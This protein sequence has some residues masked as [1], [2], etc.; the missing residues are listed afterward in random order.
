MATKLLYNNFSAG[1][2]SKAL[3]RMVSS[4]I[5]GYSA[6][7]MQNVYPLSTGGF[8]I[9]DGLKQLSDVTSL[10]IKRLIPFCISEKE[11]YIVGISTNALYIITYDNSF[12]LT[13][14]SPYLD[15][16]NYLEDEI[17]SIGFAQDYERLIL[18]HENHAPIVVSRL[19]NDDNT[20]SISVS[21]IV[22][23][24][25]NVQYEE[26][27]IVANK[28][29]YEGLFTENNFPSCVA[30]ISGRL[31]FASS[32]EN[33]YKLWASRPFEYNNFQDVEDYKAYQNSDN[34]N[35]IT[36]ALTGE[37]KKIEYSTEKPEI[38]TKEVQLSDG[39]K[40]QVEYK[41]QIEHGTK[42]ESEN[43]AS[44]KLETEYT[45]NNGIYTLT[46]YSLYEKKNID[47]EV[48][49]GNSW[50]WSFYK[51][52]S[53]AKITES[54]NY[55]WKQTITSDCAFVLEVGSDRNDRI[56]WIAE[57]NNI[58]VGT[59]SS[60]YVIESN[61]NALN[62]YIT[63]VA[64]FGS[65]SN[66]NSCQGNNKIYHIQSGNKII[67]S[68]KYSY[69]YQQQEYANIT[70]Y[71]QD[72]FES[73]IKYIMWQRV[74]EQRLYAVLNNG[75]L[76]IMCDTGVN[77]WSYHKIK[78]SKFESIAIMDD[79]TGQSIFALIKTNANK[80][81]ICKFEKDLYYDLDEHYKIDAEVISNTINSTQT[82]SAIKNVV[83][84]AV[85]SLGTPFEI[86]QEGIGKYESRYP[87]SED[88]TVKVNLYTKNTTD[89]RFSIRNIENEPFRV[90]A[91]EQ[92]VEVS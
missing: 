7:K 46:S 68:L 71:T 47:G 64:S 6:Y 56:Q 61:I 52:V 75:D 11:H 79:E 77:A 25:I 23:N 80:I 36:T 48:T 42:V 49:S 29:N 2:I 31:W 92:E 89:L 20:V 12:N 39:T 62:P 78:N 54:K 8:I 40:K 14:S 9:R 87:S 4:E 34:L 50:Y 17:E 57:S 37:T 59:S 51:S 55:V 44:W 88:E 5:Y 10:G 19:L 86:S 1:M 81:F 24:D 32:K 15:G 38:L 91:I 69:Y 76:C 21:P 41:I 27:K 65:A 63:K 18:V 3:R 35:D 45:S 33:P 60:E 67:R 83:R 28:F 43:D 26:D 22:L 74:L 84:Y 13:I 73:G 66:T 30:F 70:M 82:M 90:L 72:L 58:Y 53:D 16:I 85:D